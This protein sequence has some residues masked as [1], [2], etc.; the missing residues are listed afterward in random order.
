MFK[1]RKSF[2]SVAV[3][4][5]ASFLMALDLPANKVVDAAWVKENLGDKDIVLIDLREDSELYKKDHLPNAVKWAVGDFREERAGLPGF[6]SSPTQFERL[7]QNSGISEDSAIIFYTEGNKNATDYTAATLAVHIA[8]YFGLTNTAILNGGY[9]AWVKEGGEVNK[10]KV[11]PAKSAFKIQTIEPKDVATTYDMDDAVATKEWVLMDARN[12]A[13]YKGE[14]A[15]PKATKVGHLP[16]ANHLFISKFAVEKDGIFYINTDKD[17]VANLINSAGGDASKP[18]LWYCNT[19]WFATGGWFMSKYIAGTANV[20]AYDG[21]MVEYSTL[22]K[23][24]VV[25]E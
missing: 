18:T 19:G 23:R 7:A 12:D 16:G 5:S 9:A 25:K 22:P 21:S 14:S 17:S 4:A 24:E 15:H 2:L 1:I 6:I 20:K 13:Q 10:D 8:E 11:K 3:L